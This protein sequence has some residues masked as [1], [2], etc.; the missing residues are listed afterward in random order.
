MLRR[1]IGIV[2]LA[3]AIPAGAGAGIATAAP[4]PPATV[5]L[6]APTVPDGDMQTQ[7]TTGINGGYLTAARGWYSTNR[8]FG[9]VS[10]FGSV[11]GVQNPRLQVRILDHN[12]GF[13]EEQ[14]RYWGNRRHQESVSLNHHIPRPAGSVCTT[15]WE[16]GHQLAT[17]CEAIY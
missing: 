17:A 6:P 14:N 13:I 10:S 15:L 5:P 11:F 4:L 3:I 12:G 7:G 16:G 2:A 9:T 1:V 8:S